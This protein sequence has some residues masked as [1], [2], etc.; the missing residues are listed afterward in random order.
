MRKLHARWVPRHRSKSCH[1][2]LFRKNVSV[3]LNATHCDD[4][5]QSIHYYTPKTKQ[6]SKHWNGKGKLDPK[7]AKTLPS[8]G[9]DAKRIL[10]LNYLKKCENINDANYATL[11]DKPEDTIQEKRHGLAKKKEARLL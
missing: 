3:C 7:E 5:L 8:T 10:L 4:L 2:K 6:Q 9:R 1:A 11:L